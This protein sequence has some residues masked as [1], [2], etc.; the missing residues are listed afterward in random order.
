MASSNVSLVHLLLVIRGLHL[1]I[2]LYFLIGS[3][4]QD[5]GTTNYN[6]LEL[7]KICLFNDYLD[8]IYKLWNLTP[9]GNI[10]TS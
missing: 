6:F 4:L 5:G 8:Y 2:L 1:L 9:N 10:K 3:C 7:D